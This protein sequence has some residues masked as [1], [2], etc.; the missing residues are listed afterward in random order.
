MTS[1]ELQRYTLL[2]RAVAGF[3]VSVELCADDRPW[4]DG[5]TIYVPEDQMA[6]WRD[7][8]VVQAALL[9]AGSLAPSVVAKTMGRASLRLRYVT[10][11]TARAMHMLGDS[12]P[13]AVTRRIANI[14][15][16]PITNSPKESYERA[17]SDEKLLEAP[18][19]LG[20]VKPS[21][22]F[23]NSD[24]KT[25]GA[26]SDQDLEHG[27]EESTQEEFDDEEETERSKILELISSPLRNSLSEAMQKF[28]GAGNTPS[29]D[30][31]G[32]EEL[33]VGGNRA[34]KVGNDA[35]V[36]GNLDRAAIELL[37]RP[38]GYSYPEWDWRTKTYQPDHCTVT[39]FDPPVTYEPEELDP[40]F[41]LRMRRELAR[42][43]LA[44]ERHRRQAEGDTLDVSALV[45]FVVDNKAG[46]T[47]DERVY[48]VRRRTAHD[49]GVVV[50]L[51]ITG[52]TEDSEYGHRIFDEQRQL[53]ARLIGTFEELGDRVAGYGFQSWGRNG[54][55][56]LRI[57]SFEDRYDV[58]A[59][60]RLAAM[61]PGGFTRLGAAIRHG[62]H[63]ATEKSGVRNTL[64][65]VVGDGFPY[66]DG[67]E[68]RYAQ[69][70]SRRA[71]S[72]AVAT[73]TGCACVSVRSGTEDDVLE[74]VWGHVPY[75]KLD[76]PDDL[77]PK[78][79]RTLRRSLREAVAHGRDGRG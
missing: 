68:S 43:G 60:R 33:R 64:L 46:I 16:G 34:G 37:G 1:E 74:R 72:E 13:R 36:A 23:F 14:Y 22:V 38:V 47:G 5:Q 17:R 62:C 8:I 53:A 73:G 26:A 6:F 4:A 44:H 79:M 71:L 48:E 18:P 31:A 45:D 24:A 57:K 2:A 39:E 55:R 49:L 3:N 41:D 32:G 69:E 35:R 28:F 54:V 67:Y 21:K 77:A 61:E 70:D 27:L 30:G 7:E 15:H 12:V 25:G 51:D 52:S 56:F 10:L 75:L 20:T 78:L 11:E 58:A 76:K 63:L 50:L 19:W 29:D 65:V 9:A 59:Q 66:D 40:G 42:L